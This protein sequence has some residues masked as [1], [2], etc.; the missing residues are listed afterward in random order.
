ME[1]NFEGPEQDLSLSR[2]FIL[3]LDVDFYLLYLWPFMG[4]WDQFHHPQDLS[5]GAQVSTWPCV[6]DILLRPVAKP[7]TRG[8][9]YLYYQWD[10]FLCRGECFC[11]DCHL[12]VSRDRVGHVLLY[13]LNSRR[14]AVKDPCSRHW[15]LSQSFHHSVSESMRCL[16]ERPC[17]KNVPIQGGRSDIA[18]MCLLPF[19]DQAK[20]S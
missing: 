2:L 9:L 8:Q 17:F 18:L 5:F 11:C 10:F 4:L 1:L 6:N 19:M 15:G 13:P 7:G 3:N 14:M 16:L 12:G 20:P